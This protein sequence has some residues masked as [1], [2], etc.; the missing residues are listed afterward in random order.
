M[1]GLTAMLVLRWIFLSGVPQ[2]QTFEKFETFETMF[3]KFQN[4]AV[5]GT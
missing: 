4:I 1:S 3:E 5:F 2:F